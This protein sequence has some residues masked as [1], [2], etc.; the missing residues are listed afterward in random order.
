MKERFT[1]STMDLLKALYHVS[2]AKQYF[3]MIGVG[4]SHGA[5]FL[6]DSYAKRMDWVIKDVYDRMNDEAREEYRK[7]LVNGDTV[8]ASEIADKL[9]LINED[10]KKVIEYILTSMAKGYKV[11]VTVNN[12]KDI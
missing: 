6:M 3:E 12:E 7:S 8:F 4:Y 2:I 9:L 1:D 10:D 5:K 11:E